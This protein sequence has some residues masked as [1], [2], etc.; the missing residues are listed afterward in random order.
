[1]TISLLAAL[2]AQNHTIP[3]HT[4]GHQRGRGME[5]LLRALWGTA[6]AQD[7]SELPGLDNLAQPT[8]VLAEAQAAV[9]ATAGSDRAWFLVNGATTGLLAALLATVG[10]GDRVL[11]GRNVHRSVIAGLVLTGAKPVYLGVAVDPQWGLSLPVTSDIVAAGVAAYPDVKAVVLVSPTYEGL[12]SP[13][14]EIAQCVHEHGLPLIV[15]EAHGSHFAYHPAFPVAAL[16]AGA[17]VVVQSWHKTLGTLTQT[18]VLHLKGER[19]SPE[20][21]SQALNWVQ[22][23]SP[24]YWF[25][26]ALERAGW[27]M[28]EQGQEIY[29]RLLEWVKRYAWP[30]PRWQPP[31]VPQDPLRLTLGTWPIGLTGFELDE[32]LQPEIMAEFP[33]GRS[34]TFCLGLGTSQT[35]LEILADRLKS[36]YTEYCHHAPLPPL[37]IPPIPNLAEPTL[38]PRDAYFCPQVSVPLKVALDHISAETI[39]AYPPGIPTVIAGERITASVLATL[40]TLQELGAQIVGAADPSLQTLRICRV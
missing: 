8:G 40:Q 37:A 22:T 17:D 30:L 11:I 4:P 14:V 36:V 9:A 7:L 2:L 5:P 10:P 16:A 23:T 27:Q 19:V 6:L 13:L 25:L 39:C 12:C 31:E 32:L 34:L 3:L 33:S 29:G 35:M 18:A 20:R 28:A 38:A 15:D 21:L 24:S 1:M 26:A